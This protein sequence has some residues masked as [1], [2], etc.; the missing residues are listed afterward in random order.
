M[1]NLFE[2][3]NINILD[4]EKWEDFF[5]EHGY[6]GHFIE[7]GIQRLSDKLDKYR[8]EK[9]AFSIKVREFVVTYRFKDHENVEIVSVV[10]IDDFY[11]AEGFKVRRIFDDGDVEI[12]EL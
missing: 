7:S 5:E 6:F 9:R 2:E 8:R 1:G 12:T 10:N 3:L 11:K 4:R